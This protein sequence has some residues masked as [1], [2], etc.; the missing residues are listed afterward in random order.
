MS[1]FSGPIV[2]D[3]IIEESSN[4]AL[5]NDSANFIISGLEFLSPNVAL[6]RIN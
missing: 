5:H 4:G 6:V 3:L 1:A 2:V